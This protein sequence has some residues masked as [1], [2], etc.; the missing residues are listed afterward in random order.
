MRT[1][2][3]SWHLLK[4]SRYTLRFMQPEGTGC[5]SCMLIRRPEH[6]IGRHWY[7]P[8]N[9]RSFIR[10]STNQ[11]VSHCYATE[12]YKSFYCPLFC[13]FMT[14]V[15]QCPISLRPE[16]PVHYNL[17]KSAIELHPE[18]DDSN[19]YPFRFFHNN[20]STN[21]SSLPCVL[22]VPYICSTQN[23]SLTLWEGDGITFYSFLESEQTPI[24]CQA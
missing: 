5:S 22:C 10:W 23:C 14:R 13:V 9:W 2:L 17:H 4:Q 11:W 6:V 19:S 18:L 1:C 20:V 3:N 8:A 24:C 21:F 16:H 15:G 7:F 12:C